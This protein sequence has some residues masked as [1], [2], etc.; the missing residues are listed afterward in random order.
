[1]ACG[2]NKNKGDTP[3]VG[4]NC[5]AKI[6]EKKEFTMSDIPTPK[7][8][9]GSFANGI[10]PSGVYTKMSVKQ[11]IP[12]FKERQVEKTSTI[13]KKIEMAQSFISAI[14]SRGASNNKVNVPLK[15]LRVLSC[16]GNKDK[17]GQLP[18]CEFLRKSSTEGKF[19]CGGCG[20]GDKPLTWL[21]G[22]GEEYSKLDYPKLNCPLHMPGFTNYKQSG[23][24]EAI[25]PITR[26]Y[27]VENIN[28]TDLEQV[29]VSMHDI[30]ELPT[31]PPNVS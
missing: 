23:P 9:N 17:G 1:M 26:R 28:Y 29:Q 12:E 20:C 7:I 30:P 6:I 27:Y 2:C 8:P 16:F 31:E 10:L 22:E 3:C 5:P 11:E 21:M 24:E 15:Q 14:A 18:P 25:S 13:S 19:F 4:E